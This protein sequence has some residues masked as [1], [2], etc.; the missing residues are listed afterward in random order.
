MPLRL[1]E[2]VAREM[3]AKHLQPDDGA[4]SFVYGI[5]TPS[6]WLATLFLG[7]L[8]T[9]FMTRY[10][11]LGLTAKRLL[12]VRVSRWYGEKQCRSIDL[13]EIAEVGIDDSRDPY[14]LGAMIAMPGKKIRLTLKDGSKYRLGV[15]EN[16]KEIPGQGKH[17]DK[18]CSYLLTASAMNTAAKND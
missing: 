8:V 12:L 17:L 4:L 11:L 2:N 1:S 10:Y 16:V 9:A 7:P 3:F 13:S 18:I 6:M 14:N 5:D 15:L